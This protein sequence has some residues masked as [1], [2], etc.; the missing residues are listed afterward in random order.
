MAGMDWKAAGGEGGSYPP[1]VADF[2]GLPLS[3]CQ[4]AVLGR[5]WLVTEGDSRVE[6]VSL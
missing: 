3:G 2:L 1:A 5:V 4:E 6:G